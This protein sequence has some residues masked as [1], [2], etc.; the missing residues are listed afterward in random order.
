MGNKI[1]M[2]KLMFFITLGFIVT[3]CEPDVIIDPIENKNKVIE[4]LK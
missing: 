3:S 2:K 1:N 4:L